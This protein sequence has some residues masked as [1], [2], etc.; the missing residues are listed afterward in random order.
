MPITTLLDVKCPSIRLTGEIDMD[1]GY[2]L[3]DELKLL[4]DYYQYRTIELE[5]DSPG[6]DGEAINHLVQFLAPWSRGEGRI[7]KT[8]G[9]NQA[10]SAAAFLLSF[11][12]LGHRTAY[13]H[14]RLLYHHVRRVFPNGCSR[15]VSQLR[16]EGKQ[17]ETWENNFLEQ[18]I[19]HVG[20]LPGRKVNSNAYR[21]CLHRLMALDRPIDAK[22]ACE[23]GLIDRIE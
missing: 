7:L 11:G 14:T 19:A 2:A 15:T 16:G 6:G 18:L 8:R 22:Q 5:I 21:K 17:L 9:L 23:L 12:T 3:I 10:G 20:R 4:H 1:M 13:R